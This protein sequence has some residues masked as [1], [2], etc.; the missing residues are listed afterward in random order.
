MRVKKLAITPAAGVTVTVTCAGKGC[1]FKTK[2]VVATGK[3]VN[4]KP[5]FKKPLKKGAKITVTLSKDGL[6]GSAYTKV[7]GAPHGR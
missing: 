2:S 5:L 6:T 3:K 7:A 4:L 1:G